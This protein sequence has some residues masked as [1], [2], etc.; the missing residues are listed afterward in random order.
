MV[1]D[2]AN[3]FRHQVGNKLCYRLS[4]LNVPALR[5]LQTRDAS[6]VCTIV[7]SDFGGPNQ[8]ESDDEEDEEAEEEEFDQDSSLGVAGLYLEKKSLYVN[9]GFLKVDF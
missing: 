9:V 8:D 3:W 7:S 1:H 4:Q 2:T 5:E 6:R